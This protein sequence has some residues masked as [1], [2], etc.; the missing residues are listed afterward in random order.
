MPSPAVG[1]KTISQGANVVFVHLVRLFVAARAFGELGLEALALIF[2]IVELA[3]GVADLE[4]ANVEL[5]ALH[6]VWLV[7][8][9]LRER[10]DGEREVVDDGGL[11]EVLVRRQLRRWS[12]SLFRGLLDLRQLGP[13]R[14]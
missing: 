8:L 5:E 6:P 4:S 2:G 10:R 9:D 13:E 7:R 12:Q 11:D 1:G 14:P 3:E